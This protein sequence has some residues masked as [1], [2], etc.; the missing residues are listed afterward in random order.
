VSNSDLDEIVQTTEN[1]KCILF[2][3]L[4][5]DA[6][7]VKVVRSRWMSNNVETV[8]REVAGGNL[9]RESESEKGKRKRVLVKL[10]DD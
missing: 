10:A 5:V 2:P 6:E 9:R 4:S 3:I 7:A 1:K 8:S